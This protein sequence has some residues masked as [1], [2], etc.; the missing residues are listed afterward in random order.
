MALAVEP[1]RQTVLCFE[2]L[3]TDTYLLSRGADLKQEA[4]EEK[5]LNRSHQ[6]AGS[7]LLLAKDSEAQPIIG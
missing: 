6:E 3:P 5:K 1:P 7:K 4:D 2:W